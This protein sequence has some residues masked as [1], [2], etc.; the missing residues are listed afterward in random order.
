MGTKLRGVLA[1]KQLQ[2]ALQKDTVHISVC[3]CSGVEMAGDET[4]CTDEAVERI[5]GLFFA[6]E[7]ARVDIMASGAIRVYRIVR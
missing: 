1:R 6:G 2:A 5:A 7:L 3:T 4:Y